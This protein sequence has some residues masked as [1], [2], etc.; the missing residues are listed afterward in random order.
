MN[1]V[2]GL[3]ALDVGCGRGGDIN[4]WIHSGAFVDM[5]DPDEELLIEAK[6]RA[7]KMKLRIPFYHGDISCIPYHNKYDLIC[8]NFSLQYI[9][10]DPKTFFK[11][12]KNIKKLLKV[13][14]KFFGCIPDSHAILMTTPFKDDMGNYMVRKDNTGY[15][16]IGEKIYVYLENTPYYSDNEPKPE[17]IAYRDLLITHLENEG[18]MCKEWKSF[19]SPFEISKMYSSFIFVREY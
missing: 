16:E 18:I 1:T 7:S 3:K 17:P 14:G 9:F 2:K 15:G 12:L 8:Y 10:K 4:K 6:K 11:T 19:E 5:C 13:G